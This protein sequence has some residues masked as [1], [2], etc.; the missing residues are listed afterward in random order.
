MAGEPACSL[1]SCITGRFV[2][3]WGR[4]APPA[5]AVPAWGGPAPGL[6]WGRVV[7]ELRRA[8]LERL[9][10][11]CRRALLELDLMFQRF[12]E[13]AG[14]DVDA[15]TEA[16]LERV[17]AMEDHDLWDLVSGREE[18]GDPQLKG[19]IERLRQA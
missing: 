1:R 10:W 16:A 18:T 15:T 12:W 3:V 5:R 8:R 7:D 6:R 13:R 19:I 4:V 14:D 2:G 9:R 17:V 11:H